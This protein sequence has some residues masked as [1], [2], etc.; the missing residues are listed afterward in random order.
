MLLRSRWRGVQCQIYLL[1]LLLH[2]LQPQPLLTLQA[3]H[4]L[5]SILRSMFTSCSRELEGVLD[6]VCSL[7]TTQASMDR[8][9]TQAET[10]LEHSHTMLMQ[11]MS[12]LGLPH[13]PARRDEPT[14][15]AAASLD[16][17]ATAAAASDPPLPRE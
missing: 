16:M 7:A 2:L 6:A 15:T 4:I 8:R 5:L 12:H 10:A 14:T 3:H 13:V 1:H 17:S 11:I 9:L